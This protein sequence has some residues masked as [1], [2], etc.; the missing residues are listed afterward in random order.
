MG[1]GDRDGGVEW[2]GGGGGGAERERAKERGRDRD[3]KLCACGSMF[4]CLVYEALSY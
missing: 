2:R 1:G 3:A 4:A